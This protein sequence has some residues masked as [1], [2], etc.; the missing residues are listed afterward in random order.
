MSNDKSTADSSAAT[1]GYVAHVDWSYA[2]RGRHAYEQGKA[3]EPP[4]EL[5]MIAAMSWAGGWL[6]AAEEDEAT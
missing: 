5:H 1:E 2:D 6:D 4:D 3:C